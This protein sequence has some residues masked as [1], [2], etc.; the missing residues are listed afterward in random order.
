VT[1]WHFTVCFIVAVALD[2]LIGPKML[3]LPGSRSAKTTVVVV[4]L[5]IL[6]LVAA[7]LP[8]TTDVL[9]GLGT[10]SGLLAVD[11]WRLWSDDDTRR[12]RRRL[13]AR[14]HASLRTFAPSPIPGPV[15]T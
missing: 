9:G 15:T 8:F 1:H 3:R 12:H 7:L 11:L 4:D 10:V 5:I 2:L 14:L 13:R 6:G